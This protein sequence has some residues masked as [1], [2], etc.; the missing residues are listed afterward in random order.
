MLKFTDNDYKRIRRWII[1][2]AGII[3]HGEERAELID[4]RWLVKGEFKERIHVCG[5]KWLRRYAQS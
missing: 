4:V 3:I 1:E 5:G 2:K